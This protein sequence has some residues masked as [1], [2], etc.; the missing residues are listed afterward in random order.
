MDNT[1]DQNLQNVIRDEI[2][3]KRQKV[4]VDQMRMSVGELMSLYESTELNL[5]PDYQRLFRW[6]DEQQSDFI[7]SILLGY[8]IPPIF[9]YQNKNGKWEVVDGVQRLSTIYRFTGILNKDNDVTDAQRDKPD[10][11]LVLTTGRVLKNINGVTWEID[12]ENKKS[13]DASTKLDFRRSA[14]NIIV[15]LDKNVEEN[16][17]YEVFR[18]LNTGGSKLSDQEIRNVLILMTNKNAFNSMDQYC[19]NEAYS[20]LLS[21]SQKKEALGFKMEVLSRYIILKYYDIMNLE[22]LYKDY[23]SN[24]DIFIDNSIQ[25]I[26]KSKDIDINSDIARF[27]KLIEFLSS[28]VDYDYNFRVFNSADSKF[29]G[30]FNWLVFETIIWGLLIDN[31][32]EDLISKSKSEVIDAIKSIVTTKEFYAKNGVTVM[33]STERMIRARDY[34]RELFSFGSN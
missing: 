19:N 6:T 24:I 2:V 15:I 3:T 8:P 14:L 13:L 10:E 23:K 18:R 25:K 9:V 21:L 20:N 27:N 4:L 26:L 11:P 28:N 16:T 31:N 32:L 17:T 1:I 7:E 30:G 22:K 29:K 34:A 12:E 33:K 5:S